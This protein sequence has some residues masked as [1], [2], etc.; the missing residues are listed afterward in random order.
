MKQSTKNAI[1]RLVCAGVMVSMV[2]QPAMAATLS[3]AQVPLYLG[4][5]VPPLVMLDITKDQQLFKKAYNDYSDLDD[6]G[7]L[8][9]T[10]SHGIDYYGYFDAYKCYTYVAANKRFEPAVYN[11]KTAGQAGNST[12]NLAAKYCSA[13]GEIGRAHV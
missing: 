3:L 6:D 10:Y 1:K 5:S 9:T 11:T 4:A 8:E 12:A 2:A 13:S 7:V